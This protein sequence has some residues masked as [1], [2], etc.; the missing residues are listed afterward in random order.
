MI[1]QVKLEEAKKFAQIWNYKGVALIVDDAHCQF[2]ADFANTVLRSFVQQL[3][4][5][6]AQAA[7][8]K[9]QLVEG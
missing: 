3:Q 7:Q 5:Q 9:V 1:P 4:M 2:A 6:Q 8:P